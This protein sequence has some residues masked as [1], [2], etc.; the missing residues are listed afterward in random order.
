M[1][2]KLQSVAGLSVL[3]T[4]AAM[5]MGRIYA[6][7]AVTEGASRVVLWDIDAALLETARA[8]LSGTSTEVVAHTVDVPVRGTKQA[9]HPV[10]PGS[11]RVFRQRPAVLALQVSE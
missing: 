4:G 6:Q 9:L 2:D 1:V 11:A 10:H 8:E 5:G 3:I 7:K